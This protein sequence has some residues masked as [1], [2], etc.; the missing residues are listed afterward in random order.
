MISSFF[1]DR[2]TFNGPDH[3]FF[4]VKLHKCVAQSRRRRVP[5]T[6]DAAAALDFTTFRCC[7]IQFYLSAN[8]GVKCKCVLSTQKKSNNLNKKDFYFLNY[9]PN[10]IKNNLKAKKT[11]A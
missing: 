3:L 1:V 6:I 8:I 5:T 2:P 4:C 9:K 11:N 7:K 10:E